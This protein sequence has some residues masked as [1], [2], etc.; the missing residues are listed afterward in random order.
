MAKEHKIKCLVWDLDHTLWHGVLLE[1]SEVELNLEAVAL[2]KTLDERGILHSIASK[3]DPAVALAKLKELQLEHYF[4]YPQIGW[5]TKSEAIS[6]IAKSINIGLDTI[7]FIDDQ[8]FEREEVGFV[9]P[10]VTLLDAAD[11]TRVADMSVMIPR[12]ITDDS[13]QRRQMY[14]SDIA[15]KEVEE[16]FDGPQD[17]FLA[18]LEMVLTIAPAEEG[19]LKRAEELTQRTNQLNTTAYTYDYDELAHFAASDDHLLLV[20]GLDDKYGSYGKIGLTLIEKG[21]GVW[22]IKLLLM[23]C[24]V[25]SRGVGGVMISYLRNLAREAGV[26][27]QAE[28]VENDRNRMMYMTYKFNHF[29][30]LERRDN[31]VLFENDLSREQAYPAYMR[32]NL[33]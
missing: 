1:D 30:E 19:D 22:T 29:S 20:A 10:Q 2:L 25:M 4:L 9:H 31:W 16:R 6:A 27:L 14:Q 21:E 15:R 7:A 13:R 17:A 24:R 26:E 28:F 33:S 12:F 3:N 32:L 23:S 11:I 18:T 8:P 5:G